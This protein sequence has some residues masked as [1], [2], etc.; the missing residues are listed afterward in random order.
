MTRLARS[1]LGRAASALSSIPTYVR[2][3]SPP[4]AAAIAEKQIFLLKTG[5]SIRTLVFEPS[6]LPAAPKPAQDSVAV[7]AC[8]RT[9]QSCILRLAAWWSWRGGSFVQGCGERPLGTC[10]P[11]C[12]TGVIGALLTRPLSCS[13]LHHGGRRCGR[14]AGGAQ[15]E[16][17]TFRGWLSR[18]VPCVIGAGSRRR[19]ERVSPR[20]L[21]RCG[22][23]LDAYRWRVRRVA[24]LSACACACA[25]ACSRG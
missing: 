13:F 10:S 8:S 14:P 9:R 11:V 24:L 12:C 7:G 4:E 20:S 17:G 22:R 21:P 2:S 16:R 6:Q 15:S 25:Y 5:I 19:L 3:S 1:K 18:R 23:A